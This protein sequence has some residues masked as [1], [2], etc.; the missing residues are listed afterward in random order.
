MKN[1]VV[2][3]STVIL[4]V[5][6]SRIFPGAHM[7][8]FDEVSVTTG[9]GL[10]SDDDDKMIRFSLF[11][12]ERAKH[13]SGRPV[14]MG[15]RLQ[16]KSLDCYLN[17]YILASHGLW[18]MEGTGAP[19][20]ISVPGLYVYGDCPMCGTWKDFRISFD[21]DSRPCTVQESRDGTWEELK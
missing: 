8:M 20:R 16:T 12:N 18:L 19:R 21:T 14:W 6:A 7:G 13:P 3:P 11:C 1:P 17:E 2:D 9:S 4:V 15:D 10:R 5:I